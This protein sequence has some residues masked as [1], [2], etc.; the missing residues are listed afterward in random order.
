MSELT[1]CVVGAGEMGRHHIDVLSAMDGVVLIGVAEEDAEKL[2]CVVRGRTIIGYKDAPRMLEEQSPD[3]VVVAV[4]TSQHEAVALQCLDGGA[5]VLVE[6]PVT[7]DVEAALRVEAWSGARGSLVTVGHIERFNPVVVALK[8][9][10]AE[11]AIGRVFQ[12]VARRTGPFPSRV[13]DVGAIK[14]LATHDLDVIRFVF[15]SPFEMVFSQLARYLHSKHEDLGS[16]LGRLQNG[17]IVSMEVNWLTPT[18]V[19]EL[20]VI[21]EGGMYVV[22]Y[23]RQDL[24]LYRNGGLES[25]FGAIATFASVSEGAVIRHPIRREEPLRV[26]LA[27]F[28]QAIL[29]GGPSPVPIPEAIEALRLAEAIL[30]SAE[31]NEP[32]RPG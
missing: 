4:P 29:S 13:M 19:R 16:V 24:T 3:F 17:A 2:S 6:K 8:K 25:S 23:L 1:A 26:E 30:L 10:L 20:R 28:T 18:K 5:H 27:A 31:L 14:D 32:V 22:D 12:V 15:D 11:G 7:E 9:K 21:G